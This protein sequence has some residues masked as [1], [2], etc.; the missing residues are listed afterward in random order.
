M[1]QRKYLWG[2]LIYP[3]VVIC[4][5]FLIVSFLL[6]FI[7]PNFIT[8]FEEN[9]IELPLVTRILLGFSRNFHYILIL[10]IC[11][12]TIIFIFNMYI[13]KNKYK[14]IRTE[15]L[16][17]NIFLFGELKK[18]LLA[19]NLYHSYSSNQKYWKWMIEVWSK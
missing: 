7:L 6:I 3:I 2:I 15:K 4:L 11:T 18:F 13:N 5:T 16:L 17:I 12:L 9:Q 1:S 8:I 19:S 10:I 14:R